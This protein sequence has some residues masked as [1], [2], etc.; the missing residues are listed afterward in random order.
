MANQQPPLISIN[1]FVKDMPA[2]LAFYRRLGFAIPAAADG[3]PHV[4]VKLASGLALEFD[5]I[6]LTRAYDP[7]WREPAGGSRAVFQFLLPSRDAVDALYAELT[8]AG[9]GGHQA[10]FDAFWG[11]RYA[12]IDDPDGNLVAITSSQ[13][14]DRQGPMPKFW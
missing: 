14:P 12:V 4:E 8:A 1:F 10:P 7:G 13:D 11:A 3:Q 9:Y 5:T 2:A 6:A